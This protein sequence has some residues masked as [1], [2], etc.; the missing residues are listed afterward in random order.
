M[1]KLTEAN[2]EATMTAVEESTKER[3]ALY[4]SLVEKTAYAGFPFKD[5]PVV[6]FPALSSHPFCIVLTHSG[7]VIYVLA[8]GED[9]RVKLGSSISSATCFS[10]ERVPVAVAWAKKV[11][12]AQTVEV[13][14]RDAMAEHQTMALRLH[15]KLEELEKA[16]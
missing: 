2:I 16:A 9:G 11:A 5:V 12:I 8:P 13:W 4:K 6:E 7:Q 15:R 10:P 3:Q 1:I 14:S